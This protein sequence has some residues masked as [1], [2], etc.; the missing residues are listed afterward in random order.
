M[1]VTDL[2][3]YETLNELLGKKL[4]LNF[5]IKDGEALPKKLCA[6]TFCQY[7]FY[8][9]GDQ[10]ADEEDSD[11]LD[12]IG[13]I[14]DD[15]D[16]RTV[17]KLRVFKTKEI[18]QKTQK[19]QWEYKVSHSVDIDEEMLLKLQSESLAVAV[20]GMQEGREKFGAKLVGAGNSKVEEK[21]AN[22]IGEDQQIIEKAI[23]MD[24]DM[25][26]K[27]KAL[28]K[29]NAKLMRLL[30]EREAQVL[31]GQNV[32]QVAGRGGEGFCAVTC[33]LF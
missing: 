26:A 8:A 33:N 30:G 15:G 10:L 14:A 7:E 4:K 13:D 24:P 25:A 3:E 32:D 2:I 29:E 6:R 21:K 18:E 11:G 19:P 16:G 1:E 12:N 17:K 5:E 20:F 23:A 27:L 22:E 28:E 9:S 31:A